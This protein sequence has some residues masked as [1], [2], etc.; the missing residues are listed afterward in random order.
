[1]RRNKT[2]LIR[3]NTVSKKIEIIIAAQKIKYYLQFVP[4][5]IMHL[6]NKESINEL[7]DILKEYNHYYDSFKRN[8]DEDDIDCDHK[9]I[10][11]FFKKRLSSFIDN[12]E[13][14]KKSLNF[15]FL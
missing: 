6:K 4:K 2:S 3:Y 11:Y 8:F 5:K 10:K 14:I 9:I 12:L 1:M 7:L 13:H 15:F